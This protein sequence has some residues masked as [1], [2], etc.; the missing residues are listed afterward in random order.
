MSEFKKL[1][2]IK[3]SKEYIL[4]KG[5]N[6]LYHHELVSKCRAVWNSKLGG[7]LI[8]NTNSNLN[9]IE[10]IEQKLEK[11]YKNR[12][13]ENQKLK[14]RKLEK[15]NSRGYLTPE[16]DSSDIDLSVCIPSKNK[17]NENSSIEIYSDSE[18]VVSLARYIRKLQKQI[19]E[20]KNLITK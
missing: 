1:Q 11:I 14:N 9:H 12:Q 5:D 3:H 2:K 18:D 6:E 16:S 7:W 4:L 10:L 17:N 20:I 8:S 15:R 19:D 13:V